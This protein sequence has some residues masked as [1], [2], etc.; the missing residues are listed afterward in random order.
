MV[1][2]TSSTLYIVT[3]NFRRGSL[4]DTFEAGMSWRL[5]LKKA[6]DMQEALA[7]AVRWHVHTG[8]CCVCNATQLRQTAEL[9]TEPL[10]S[11]TVTG[12]EV[13]TCMRSLR[14]T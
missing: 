1:L 14:Q 13:N 4:H 3:R 9:Q 10:S 6:C 12:Y 5:Y 11:H 7:W 2:K 8:P